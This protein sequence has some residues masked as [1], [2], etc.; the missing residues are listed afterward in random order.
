MFVYLREI[1]E[2][3][4]GLGFLGRLYYEHPFAMVE[5]EGRTPV[6]PQ[7]INPQSSNPQPSTTKET[8]MATIVFAGQL[9]PTT[10][11]TAIR[12]A[13]H[14]RQLQ[15]VYRR[16]RLGAM[17]AITALAAAVLL[18]MFSLFGASAAADG[19]AG[20]SAAPKYVVAQPGDTLWS[21][22]ERIA[23]NAP[24][25][26]VVDQLVRLNGTAITSGQLIRIP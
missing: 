15:R 21:I 5:A 23:P 25:S 12:Q 16:R 17:F 14:T 22:G 7:P 18:S 20:R 13:A 6:R 3:V 11:R 8:P 4:A 1:P 9:Q 24:I 26:E 2:T 10:R 19:S